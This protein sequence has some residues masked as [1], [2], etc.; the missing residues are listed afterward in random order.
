MEHQIDIWVWDLAPA[1]VDLDRLRGVLTPDETARA[2]RF[3]KA[4][5]RIAFCAGRGVLREILASYIGRGAAD[6]RFSYCAHGKPSLSGGPVF[7]LSHSK[8][9]ACLAVNSGPDCALGVDIEA[10]RPI[11]DAVAAR[12]FSPAEYAALASLPASQW[13]DGFFRC[14]TRKEAFVKACGQGLS[15][16]LHAFDVTLN[17]QAPACLLRLDQGDPAAWQM[18]HMDLGP[19]LIGAIA[20][21]TPMPLRPR[22]RQWGGVAPHPYPVRFG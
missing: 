1:A 22:L 18:Q 12:F 3:V 8:G 4:S 6:L 7:N 2:D 14:W 13:Q 16:P 19:H 20:V 10:V 21:Q 17:P 11:E 5:D 9:V 15:M